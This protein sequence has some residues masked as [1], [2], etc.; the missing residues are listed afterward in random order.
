[1][2]TE[3]SASEASTA[4]AVSTVL[5]AQG[6]VGCCT[7][8]YCNVRVGVAAA[9]HGRATYPR[10][11]RHALAGAGQQLDVLYPAL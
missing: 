7:A 2:G 6:C 1:M 9:D 5:C 3:D 11:R 4:P 10:L 8:K